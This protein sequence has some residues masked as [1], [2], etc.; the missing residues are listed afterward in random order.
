MLAHVA[1]PEGC[2]QLLLDRRGSTP[3]PSGGAAVV[4]MFREHLVNRGHDPDTAVV[5]IRKEVVA[6]WLSAL[7]RRRLRPRRRRTTSPVRHPRAGREEGERRL[8]A[9]SGPSATSDNPT[10]I[11]PARYPDPEVAM[12]EAQR[13]RRGRNNRSPG[14]PAPRGRGARPPRG[15]RDSADTTCTETFPPAR[16]SAASASSRS[17]R[18]ATRTRSIPSAAK[19]RANSSPRPDD[20][21]VTSAARLMS[22]RTSAPRAWNLV[23]GELYRFPSTGEGSRDERSGGPDAGT[24][25]HQPGGHRLRVRQGSGAAGARADPDRAPLRHHAAGRPG[26]VRRP[27]APA[28]RRTRTATPSPRAAV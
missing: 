11:H 6:G 19:R 18:R 21:P 9:G 8:G 27:G 2:Q 10:P 4:A 3:T 14:G 22:G 28:S 16:S 23:P 17:R 20:A 24:H 15:L 13:A 7:E 12:M 5:Q 25:G 26:G 1:D